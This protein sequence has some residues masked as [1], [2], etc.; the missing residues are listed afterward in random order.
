MR[1]KLSICFSF[2]TVAKSYLRHICYSSL[3]THRC[4]FTDYLLLFII[5]Y[6]LQNGDMNTKNI[7]PS[8]LQKLNQQMAKMMDPRVLQQMGGMGGLQ[9]MMKQLQGASSSLGNRRNN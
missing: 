8:Q 7:N 6:W 3:S 4:Y 2:F 5:V 1:S 9:N